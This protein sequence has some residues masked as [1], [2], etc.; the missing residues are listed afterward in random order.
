MENRFD[1]LSYPLDGGLILAV[2]YNI[3]LDQTAGPRMTIEEGNAI[4]RQLSKMVIS[5]INGVRIRVDFQSWS[6]GKP[7]DLTSY[8]NW[9]GEV[10][11]NKAYA[12]LSETKRLAPRRGDGGASILIEDFIVVFGENLIAKLGV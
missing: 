6:A 9:N 10:A 5:K 12:F 11:V 4:L 3:A 8:G 2:L 7:L 1:F